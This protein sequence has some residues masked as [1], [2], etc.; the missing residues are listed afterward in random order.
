MKLHTDVAALSDKCRQ[1]RQDL[2][3][4]PETAFE[5][6]STQAYII[7]ELKRYSPD[8]IQTLAGTGVKAVF[9]APGAETTIAFRADMDGLQI[10]ELTESAYVSEHPG[11]MHA[12]GHDGH[13]TVLLLLAGFIHRYREQLKTNVVLLFQPAEEGGGGAKRMIDEGALQNPRVDRIYGL[14]VWPFVEK[15]KIGVRWGPMM[16]KTSEFDIIVHGVSA[17][18]ASPQMGVDAVVV[19]AEFI[20]MLQTAITRNLDPHQDALLTIG[21]IQ[22]GVARNIIA[23]KVVMNATLR[24]FSTEVFENLTSRIRAMADGLSL[25]TGAAFEVVTK[26]QYPRVDNPRY[27]VE[28]FYNYVDMEDVVLVEPVMAA[29]D[30]SCYQKEIPGLFFFLGVGG[31]KNRRPLHSGLFDFDEDALLYGVEI[32]RRILGLG[33]SETG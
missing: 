14:H 29:E 24:V 22:G 16:A 12:C 6:H 25:A 9:Y 5:E 7:N 8:S 26:M 13:M 3:R 17:H 19:A 10:D 11:K 21:K 31:G 23:D 28:D 15:G 20:L 30:F 32:Y 1:L 2:H 27:M 18:G 33:H 4:M